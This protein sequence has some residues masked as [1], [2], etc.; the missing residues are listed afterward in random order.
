MGDLLEIKDLIARSKRH[1]STVPPAQRQKIR[2]L[3]KMLKSYDNTR[4]SRRNDPT[5]VDSARSVILEAVEFTSKMPW[6]W[7]TEHF[8]AWGTH[9]FLDLGNSAQTQR[10]KQNIFRDFHDIWLPTSTAATLVRKQF[11]L[12]I[13]RIC[14]TESMVVHKVEND[15]KTKARAFTIEELRQFFD[16]MDDLIDRCAQTRSKSLKAAVRDKVL[17]FTMVSYGVRDNELRM[18]DTTD[19]LP[20]PLVPE[21]GKYGSFHVRF[22]KRPGGTEYKE[23]MVYTID[24]DTPVML[25]FW[26]GDP[27]K[28][29]AG[30]RQE[31]ITERTPDEDKNATFFSERG[32]RIST[33]AIQENF[34]R[35]VHLFGMYRPGLTPHVLRATYVTHAQ[36]HK[37]LSPF[38]VQMQVGHVF[39]S[40]TM[41]YTR[42]SDLF[43]RKQLAIVA[44]RVLSEASPREGAPSVEREGA[45]RVDDRGAQRVAGITH[46]NGEGRSGAY[47]AGRRSV[48]KARLHRRTR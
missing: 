39:L 16:E 8:E 37:A 41:A 11:G 26:F 30:W 15:N 25:R 19:F 28:E 10:R 27:E 6:E 35:Y 7:T 17:F 13:G 42:L 14:R 9:L 3:E 38:F 43:H 48:R 2:L 40:T 34:K 5:T 31:F 23:R 18:A 47:Q 29:W 1:P 45:Q 44:D 24:K 12:R 21:F 4:Y 46:Y 20:N 22:G 33:R 32:H 36:E